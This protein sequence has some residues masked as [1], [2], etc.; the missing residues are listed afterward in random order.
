V[1]GGFG[2]D[3]DRYDGARARKNYAGF[4]PITRAPGKKVVLARHVRNR[5]LADAL[6]QQGF[7]A[8]NPSPG[9]RAY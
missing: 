8:L 9:A 1:L 3:P 2:D 4:A 7:C 5:R 6:H